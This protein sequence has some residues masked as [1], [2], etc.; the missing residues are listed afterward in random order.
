MP[1][2]HYK[3]TGQETGADFHEIRAAFD[4][5]SVNYSMIDTDQYAGVDQNAAVIIQSLLELKTDLPIILISGSK[6]SAESL[7][8]LSDAYV[9]Q[10]PIAAWFNVCGNIKGTPLANLYML[11]L[12]KQIGNFILKSIDPDASRA[13]NDMTTDKCQ[14]RLGDSNLPAQLRVYNILTHLKRPAVDMLA[15]FTVT[16][17][18]GPT[19]GLIPLSNSIVPHGETIVFDQQ[20]HLF[21]EAGQRNLLFPCISNCVNTLLSQNN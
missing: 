20:R 10:L 21:N 7:V 12:A 13:L 9:H 4:V 19:D 14:Q 18:Y 1:G 8:A 17:V 6:G 15:Y 3:I 16:A 2:W 11:P 5:H